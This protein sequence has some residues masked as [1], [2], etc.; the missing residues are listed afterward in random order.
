MGQGI[1]QDSFQWLLLAL[2]IEQ[3][4]H[5]YEVGKR[6]QARFESILPRSLSRVYDALKR[7]EARGMIEPA[8]VEIT[9]P[10][11]A[12]RA[13]TCRAT[14]AGRTAYRRWAAEAKKSGSFV[15]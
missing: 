11:H 5:A 1:D 4:S 14:D 10:Q 9:R 13:R 2:V 7:L 8:P 6:Y 3:P 12:T 15:P